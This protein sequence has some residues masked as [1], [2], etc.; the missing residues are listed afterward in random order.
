[1]C[2]FVRSVL[3]GHLFVWVCKLLKKKMISRFSN[4]LHALKDWTVL[5][6]LLP[7]GVETL[8]LPHPGST[9]VR[10]IEPKMPVCCSKR[11]NLAVIV[12][13]MQYLLRT[14][15]CIL[16]L[17]LVIFLFFQRKIL[18]YANHSHWNLSCTVA[19]KS[20]NYTLETVNI[21][22][23]LSCIPVC[24]QWSGISQNIVDRYDGICFKD[25]C[26][27]AHVVESICSFIWDIKICVVEWRVVTCVQQQYP[28]Q[29]KQLLKDVSPGWH[30]PTM[31]VFPWAWIM[32]KAFVSKLQVLSN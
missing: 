10:W 24:C 11:S 28:L 32:I 8:K 25:W 15:T 29:W 23:L 20:C 7:A 22:L 21:S 1:M 18:W 9:G 12:G 3:S 5:I 2:L 13:T 30:F 17:F 16:F 4:L 26:T 6:K 14:T 31:C 19:L 27:R